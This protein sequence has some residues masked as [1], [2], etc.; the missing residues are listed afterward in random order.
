[1]ITALRA[2]EYLIA[3]ATAAGSSAPALSNLKL[4]KL[5]YYA[6]GLYFAEC[7][8]PMF[9]EDFQAWR[10][11]P[12]CSGVYHAYKQYGSEPIPFSNVNPW[13]IPPRSRHIL[14]QVI[15][16]Y[17][18][19]SAWDLRELTHSEDPW[20]DVYKDQKRCEQISK[21]S[22]K[23]FFTSLRDRKDA[24]KH[25]AQII[26][27][28]SRMIQDLSFLQPDPS[29]DAVLDRLFKQYTPGTAVRRR[30]AKR[31]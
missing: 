29:A 15:V 9:G 12:V 20:R 22:M 18:E 8:E 14:D 30:I 6:Q 5:L 11:G 3:S 26:D 19:M 21:P 1:M 24:A 28:A 4:Q 17:G 23:R 2:A 25:S 27:Q 7:G 10:H 13:D 31:A 16:E